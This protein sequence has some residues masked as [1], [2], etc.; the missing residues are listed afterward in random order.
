MLYP[1]L[2]SKQII[3]EK[4]LVVRVTEITESH[5]IGNQFR[6]SVEGDG[7]FSELYTEPVRATDLNT[8]ITNGLILGKKRWDKIEFKNAVKCVYL[9]GF[10]DRVDVGVILPILHYLR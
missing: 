6:L 9:P 5:I 3:K 4:N 1:K 10:K 8:Y 2:S 7:S